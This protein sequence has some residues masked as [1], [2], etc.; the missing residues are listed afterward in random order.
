MLPF[1]VPWLALVVITPSNL[2]IRSVVVHK[3]YIEPK[4]GILFP[5]FA[6]VIAFYLLWSAGKFF[7]KYRSV[8]GRERVQLRY[9]AAGVGVFIAAM[10]V[11]DVLLPALGIFQLNMFGSLFSVIFVGMTAYAIM[12]HQ[13]LDIRIVLQK[14]LLYGCTI[15][16]ITAIFF[17]IEAL[18]RRFTQINGWIDDVIAAVAGAFG[19]VWFRGIFERMTD[20]FFFR[21]DYE[22]AEAVRELGP[23][24]HTSI[25]L[26][27]LFSSIHDFLM[28]TVELSQWKAKQGRGVAL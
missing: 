23:L 18:T 28:R 5:V 1:L 17:T 6:V 22:Y 15:I 26:G 4:N 12:R 10:F 2:F 21:G 16:L 11:A 3:N 8:R 19:F 20:R 24:L 13:F 9:F 7:I 27:I 14:G 25:D